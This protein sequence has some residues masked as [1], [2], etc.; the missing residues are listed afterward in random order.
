MR[1]A[2]RQPQV[3]PDGLVFPEVPRWKDGQLWFSDYQIWLPGM[4]GTVLVVDAGGTARTVVDQVPGGPATG[5]GWLAARAARYWLS[6]PMGASLPTPISPVLPRTRAT[7]WWSTHPAVSTWAV[8]TLH[9]PRPPCR[10]S[11]PAKRSEQGC[12]RVLGD[13]R[14]RGGT[15][16]FGAW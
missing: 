6:A 14:F 3:V 7:T 12:P 13:A 2:V 4:T 5:L 15:S 11:D 10:N 16:G 9:P 8:P 1:E